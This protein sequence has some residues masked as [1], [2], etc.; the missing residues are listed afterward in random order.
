MIMEN[1]YSHF[2]ELNTASHCQSQTELNNI[3]LALI[4]ATNDFDKKLDQIVLKLP[5]QQRID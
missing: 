3:A 4:M 1:I 5:P 2:D